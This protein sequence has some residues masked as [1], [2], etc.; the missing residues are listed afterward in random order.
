[1]YSY[2]NY[3]RYIILVHKNNNVYVQLHELHEIYTP[4]TTIIDICAFLLLFIG[5]SILMQSIGKDS[6]KSYLQNTRIYYKTKFIF[7][8]L[9]HFWFQRT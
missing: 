6:N 5:L 9:N 7:I 8:F 3:M 4:G 2:M 1:M